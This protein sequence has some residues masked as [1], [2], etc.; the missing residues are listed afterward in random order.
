MIAALY[1]DGGLETARRFI[2]AHWSGLLDSPPESGDAKTR[3]QEWSQAR[4]LGIPV[5]S[6]IG[7]EGPDHL[8]NFRV[9]VQIRGH[10]NQTGLGASKRLAERA[11]AEA[12]LREVE[13]S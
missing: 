1:L 8:P 3:L 5:Y 11:A 6:V 13:G 2:R 12:M 4:G 9:S 10:A 7:R